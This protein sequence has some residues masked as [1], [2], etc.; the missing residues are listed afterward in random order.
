MYDFG[1]LTSKFKTHFSTNSTDKKPSTSLV[2]LRKQKGKPLRDFMA[3]FNEESLNIKNLSPDM[4][5]HA[6]LAA[7]KQGLSENSLAKKPLANMEDLR[8][9]AVKYI[10][11][12]EVSRA[13]RTFEKEAQP[14]HRPEAKHKTNPS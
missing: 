1:N 9:R 7:L 6:I 8:A 11:L 4:A 12:E 5:M 3:K 10:N 2:S 13:K 14:E